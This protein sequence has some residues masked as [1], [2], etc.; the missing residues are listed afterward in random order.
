MQPL[1]I[2]NG[3]S[4]KLYRLAYVSFNLKELW[5]TVFQPMTKFEKIWLSIFSTIILTSTFY[6]SYT[7]TEWSDWKSISLNW[8]ISPVSALTGVICVILVARASIHN[9]SFGLV[10]SLLYGALCWIS[11]YYGDWLLNWFFFI[12]TQILI[13]IFWKRNIRPRS[14]D[15]VKIAQFKRWQTFLTVFLCLAALVGF[16]FALN[17]LDSWFIIDMKRNV[18]IYSNITA[19]YGISLLGP[20]MD[21][22][23]EVLQIA[24]QFLCIARSTL[25]WPMWIATNVITILMWGAV[26]ITDRNQ[27]PIA[28]PTLVMWVAFLFNSVYGAINWQR[29]IQ[30]DV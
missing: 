23:T 13:F 29:G 4:G 7:G 22:S 14:L 19:V 18:S 10:Q 3:I 20:M 5:K 1:E 27:L 8:F 2:V 15:I 6:F 11:G 26:A 12:P 28:M 17:S 24:A 16:G 30:V 21:S 25:Q 9:Y